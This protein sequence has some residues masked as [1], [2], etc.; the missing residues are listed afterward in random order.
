MKKK[1]SD[2]LPTK[3]DLYLPHIDRT[4]NLVHRRL[5]S[6]Y[7]QEYLSLEINEFQQP[8]PPQNFVDGKQA[9]LR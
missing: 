4:H 2:R 6:L 5:E 1:L 3:L 7:T 8:N 9:I